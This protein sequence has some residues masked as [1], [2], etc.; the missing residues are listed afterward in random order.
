MAAIT[1]FRLV[2]ASPPLQL[3]PPSP[4]AALSPN[5]LAHD[6]WSTEHHCAPM[7]RD[8]SSCPTR[9]LRN[10]PGPRQAPHRHPPKSVARTT[11]VL[12]RRVYE[13]GRPCRIKR[14]CAACVPLL[15]WRCQWTVFRVTG[16]GLLALTLDEA[17]R[18]AANIAHTASPSSNH[19]WYVWDW[20]HV[21]TPTMGWLS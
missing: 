15:W 6:S 1:E 20:S 12:V 11:T 16:S 5:L 9:P 21:G 3:F 13:G 19:S 18:I 4:A 7:L 10:R 2:S 17:R 14:N 8:C